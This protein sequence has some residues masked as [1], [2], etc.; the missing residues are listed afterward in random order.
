M[1]TAN[2]MQPTFSGMHRKQ[3]TIFDLYR[4][5]TEI[6]EVMSTHVRSSISEIAIVL[7]NQ[8]NEISNVNNLLTNH[9]FEVQNLINQV[10]D[11]GSNL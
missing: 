2:G 9:M 1:T 3:F 10:L 6:A 5:L 4:V 7:M 8:V 11:N